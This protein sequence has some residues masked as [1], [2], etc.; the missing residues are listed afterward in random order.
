MAARPKPL[1]DEDSSRVIATA[2]ERG[3]VLPSGHF[4]RRMRERNFDMTDA[5]TVLEARKQIKAV[6]NDKA[7]A[8]NYDVPGIDL[9]GNE[10]TIRI[11]LADERNGIIL[12]TGF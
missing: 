12:V 9:D 3:N 6:W 1:K 10:L 2:L 7:V 8:W 11:A 5:I 4:R